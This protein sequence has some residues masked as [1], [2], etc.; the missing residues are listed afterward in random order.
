MIPSL[1]RFRTFVFDC[2]GVVLDS[3]DLKTR[4]FR[5]VAGEFGDEAAER[6]V[7]HHRLHGGVS[8]FEKLHWLVD[9][10]LG[11][12]DDRALADRLLEDFGRRVRLALE[13]CPT[14]PGAVEALSRCA[15]IGDCFLVSGGLEEELRD[16]FR[17]RGLDRPLRAIHGSPASKSEILCG[18]RGRGELVLPCLFFGDS[19][20]DHDVARAFGCDFVFLHGR[21]EMPGW[22]RWA[23]EG[24]IVR[25][26][27]LA[28]VLAAQGDGAR[29][30][31]GR[32]APR[33][34]GSARAATAPRGGVGEV[35]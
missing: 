20:L 30:E 26:K 2:D 10:V 13:S 32:E 17:A 24:G 23:D 8:R 31:G 29:R 18:L 6:L 14:C 11:R 4:V 12:P 27:D 1:D 5:E 33:G 3:N 35:G 19:R 25:A 22:R 21:T 28:E 7:E 15:G 9:E 34:A 16:V